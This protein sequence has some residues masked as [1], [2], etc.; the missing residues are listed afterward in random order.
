M[1]TRV[2]RTVRTVT[3]K[4]FRRFCWGNHLSWLV[5]QLKWEPLCH[6]ERKTKLNR[7]ACHQ[8]AGRLQVHHQGVRY[9]IGNAVAASTR[10]VLNHMEPIQAH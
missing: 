4:G 10:L 2:V 7:S 1:P 3:S 9:S 6:L 8:W 5:L